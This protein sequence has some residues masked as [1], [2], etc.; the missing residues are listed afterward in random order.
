EDAEGKK[1][2]FSLVSHN[3]TFLFQAEDEADLSA[4]V[5]VISNSRT[6]ALEKAFGDN[7]NE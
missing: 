1:H 6:E 5:S 4:W 3:R 7:D 2:S